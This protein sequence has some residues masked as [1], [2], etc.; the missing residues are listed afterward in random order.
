MGFCHHLEMRRRKILDAE[1]FTMS[2]FA[3][4]AIAIKRQEKTIKWREKQA[5]APFIGDNKGL[6]LSLVNNAG[7][8]PYFSVILRSRSSYL[9]NPVLCVKLN[10]Q[11]LWSLAFAM[12]VTRNGGLAFPKALDW[13]RSYPG[14]ETPCRFNLQS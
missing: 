4:N 14:F 13:E 3:P 8:S 2:E 5:H 6:C 10:G 1:N 7:R 9:F 11:M 12:D